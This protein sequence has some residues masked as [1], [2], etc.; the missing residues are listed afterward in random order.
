MI[1]FS[2]GLGFAGFFLSGFSVGIDNG[3]F[4]LSGLSSLSISWVM[5]RLKLKSV[6]LSF[7]LFLSCWLLISASVSADPNFWVYWWEKFLLYLI[8]LLPFATSASI[9]FSCWRG[10]F[11][12]DFLVGGLFDDSF[13]CLIG[14]SWKITFSVEPSTIS[15]TF[16]IAC[17]KL[18]Q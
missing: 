13:F 7:F 16:S 9:F 15:I 3:S 5:F 6:G 8:Y 12:G 10:F 18:K 4:V 1:A 17:S 2:A 11:L 14:E